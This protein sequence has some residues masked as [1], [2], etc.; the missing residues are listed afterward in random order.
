MKEIL[1]HQI[2]NDFAK[3]LNCK[4]VLFASFIQAIQDDVRSKSQN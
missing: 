2:A 1:T 3:Y 4:L